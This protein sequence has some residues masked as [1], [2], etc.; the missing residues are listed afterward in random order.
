MSKL[1]MFNPRG[2]NSPEKWKRF[3][4]DLG[5]RNRAFIFKVDRKGHSDGEVIAPTAGEH[6]ELQQLQG[7]VGGYIEVI[8]WNGLLVVCNEDGRR[9]R[10]PVNMHASTNLA[11]PLVGNVIVMSPSMMK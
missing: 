8:S 5:V 9:L 10:L 1:C 6:F 2:Y 7:L 3:I 11:T 4:E